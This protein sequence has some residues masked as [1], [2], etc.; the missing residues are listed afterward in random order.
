MK[1]LILSIFLLSVVTA[2]AQIPSIPLYM[3]EWAGTQSGFK[4][5][6]VVVI[7]DSN[8]LLIRKNVAKG[9]V[10]RQDTLQFIY[11]VKQISNGYEFSLSAPKA[12]K[13]KDKTITA[14]L[15]FEETKPKSNKLCASFS[16]DFEE[17]NKSLNTLKLTKQISKDQESHFQ[18]SQNVIY[19]PKLY[20][21]DLLNNISNFH[22]LEDSVGE[23][24]RKRFELDS[25]YK[26]ESM[27]FTLNGKKYYGYDGGLIGYYMQQCWDQGG[28]IIKNFLKIDKVIGCG[29]RAII[30]ADGLNKPYYYYNCLK[31]VPLK[32]KSEFDKR[33]YK[34]DL[35]EVRFFDSN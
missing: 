14:Q 10:L 33:L 25:N 27:E 24:R 2:N 32:N 6:Y 17:G 13:N 1:N 9:K 28:L 31:R 30:K 4:S 7:N 8:L 34:L 21:A 18:S 29:N 12:L 20:E 15:L 3:G 16:V 22:H 26:E 23:V 19:A 11:Q 35:V 5:P